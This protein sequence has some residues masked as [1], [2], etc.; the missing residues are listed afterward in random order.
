VRA[1]GLRFAIRVSLL[2]LQARLQAFAPPQS[3]WDL[4]ARLAEEGNIAGAVQTL[5]SALAS[6][7]APTAA[8][9]LLLSD[10]YVQMKRP[11]DAE[12]TLRKGLSAHPADPVL[13]LFLGELLMDAQ[14]YSL[15]AGQLLEHSVRTAPRDPE[16]RHSYAQWAHMNMRERICVAQ[17]KA[18]LLLPGQDDVTLLKMNTL[19]GI[20]SGRIEDAA[21]ARAAFRRANAINLRQKTYDPAVAW[22][23][24]Q[25]LGRF[26]A[27]AEVQSIVGE[28]LE[29]VPE[30]GLAHL[31]RAKYF[32]REGQPD[33]AAEAARLVLHSAGNDLNVERAAHGILARSFTAL[34]ET[35]NASR[36]QAWIE[37]H[38]NLETP[39]K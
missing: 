22:Q 17:E 12:Q 14:S 34:G 36:E 24:V 32:D 13:E 29:R 20:C 10:C 26:G 9:Y 7:P 23:Y 4:G 2:V 6:S 5:T 31:E 27:D 11:A 35:G 28:I 30:F 25:F 18:A 37:A 21:G 19:L 15:E 1:A 39:V 3:P 38:P 8:P 16:A 33:K